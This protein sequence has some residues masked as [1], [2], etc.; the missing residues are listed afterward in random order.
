MKVVNQILRYIMSKKEQTS[1]ETNTFALTML[2]LFTAF[3]LITAVGG[4]REV[5]S[6][7]SSTETA[8]VTA[9]SETTTAAETK[10]DVS[11]KLAGIPVDSSA[12]IE[13]RTVSNSDGEDYEQV[14]T[15][16]SQ[17]AAPVIARDYQDWMSQNGYTVTDER[18]GQKAASLKAVNGDSALVVVISHFSNSGMSNVEIINF[19]FG[20]TDS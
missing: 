15:F 20:N 1:G 17:M 18:I 13:N 9:A 14:I 2:V 11:G 4:D 19:A 6:S 12:V 3:V 8:T 10:A 16:Q 7:D 5:A